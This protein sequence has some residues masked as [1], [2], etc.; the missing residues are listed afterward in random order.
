[1]KKLALGIAIF[2]ICTAA[3]HASVWRVIYNNGEV[4][5]EVDDETVKHSGSVVFV[6]SRV[7]YRTPQMNRNVG[8][9]FNGLLARQEIDC[10]ADTFIPRSVTWLFNGDEVARE[11]HIDKAD[12][13]PDTIAQI[14]ERAVC[15]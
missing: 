6:W 4:K 3:A 11:A 15:R 7:T 10:K 12:I 9:R 8:L 1:M 13:P 5:V 14:V 2:A